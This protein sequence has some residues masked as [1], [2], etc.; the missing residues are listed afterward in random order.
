MGRSSDLLSGEVLS[1]KMQQIVNALGGEH[2]LVLA[3]NG[4]E[5]NIQKRHV[6]RLRSQSTSGD[7]MA[8]EP[9]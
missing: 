6:S 8:D 2:D 5:G 1:A 9:K 3:P 7:G 4:T